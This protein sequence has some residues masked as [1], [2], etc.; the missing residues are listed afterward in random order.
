MTLQGEGPAT[1]RRCFFVRLGMCNLHCSWCDT[2]YTWDHSRYDVAAE[3]PDTPTEEIVQRLVDLGAKRDSMV[4]LSGGEPLMHHTK[5]LPLLVREFEWHV[6]TNGTIPPPRWWTE[7]VTHTSVSPKVITHDSDPVKKRIKPR[8]LRKW[9]SLADE[10]HAIFKF[11][12]AT[13]ADLDLVADLVADIGIPVTSVWVMPEGTD[14]TT[15]DA[16]LADITQDAIDRG[17]NVTGRMHTM[18]W[19]QERGR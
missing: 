1:G 9:A 14:A 2:P 18:I 8:S 19:G 11:V 6:E 17:F 7:H 10:G 16:R 15:L 4:V 3:C 5:L 13:T 12:V